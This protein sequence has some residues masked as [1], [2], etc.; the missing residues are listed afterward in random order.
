M[1][2]MMMKNF[3]IE[4]RGKWNTKTKVIPVTSGATGII[5]I[6]FGKYLSNVPGNYNFKELQETAILGTAYVHVGKY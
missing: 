5:E 1:M 4:I 3:T 2:M 6:L